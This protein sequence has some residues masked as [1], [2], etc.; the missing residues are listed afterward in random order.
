MGV[1]FSLTGTGPPSPGWLKQHR[2]TDWLRP[3]EAREEAACPAPRGD[4]APPACTAAARG[5]CQREV[6]L[7]LFFLRLLL[8]FF[9]RAAEHSERTEEL[10]MLALSKS[11]SSR[12]SSSLCGAGEGPVSPGR[13]GALSPRPSLGGGRGAWGRPRWR[14]RGSVSLWSIAPLHPARNRQ[15]EP[16]VLQLSP[17]PALQPHFPPQYLSPGRALHPA[18]LLHVRPQ[19]ETSR[20]LRPRSLP[21]PLLNRTCCT[22][23]VPGPACPTSRHWPSPS[24]HAHAPSGLTLQSRAAAAEQEAQHSGVLNKYLLS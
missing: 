16:D 8:L 23:C 6:L 18:K 15:V 21:R 10:W 22:A 14:L 20:T 13:C 4:C 24:V 5:P 7:L 3:G 19:R 11:D 1:E 12:S 2:G 9:P 17:R